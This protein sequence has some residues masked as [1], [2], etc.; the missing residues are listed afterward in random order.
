MAAEPWKLGNASSLLV[1]NLGTSATPP[2]TCRC[3]T[4]PDSNSALLQDPHPTTVQYCTMRL[5]PFLFHISSREHLLHL[6][7]SYSYTSISSSHLE[8]HYPKLSY[9][10]IMLPMFLYPSLSSSPSLKKL[11]S[12]QPLNILVSYHTS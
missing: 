7:F 6:T 3:T 2:L 12:L 9:S 5:L 8:L 10:I 4:R 1:H 11:D